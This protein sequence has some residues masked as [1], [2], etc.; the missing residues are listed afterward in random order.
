MFPSALVQRTPPPQPTCAPC[1][2]PA[3]FG[4][5]AIGPEPRRCLR[6]GPSKSRLTQFSPFWSLGSWCEGE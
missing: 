2:T 4:P 5:Y 6:S 1:G 3:M